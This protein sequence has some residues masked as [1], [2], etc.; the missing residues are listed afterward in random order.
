[1][2]VYDTKRIPLEAQYLYRRAQ[3]MAASRKFDMALKCL[4]QAVCIAPHFSKAYHEMGR[5]LEELGRP[6]EASEKYCREL[7]AGPLYAETRLWS[8]SGIDQPR[9]L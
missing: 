5:C 9:R 8:G 7:Q 3:E 6:D 4:K 2:A 1:M